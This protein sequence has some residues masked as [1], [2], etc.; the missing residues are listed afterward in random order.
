MSE[1]KK[2]AVV[3]N[4]ATAADEA[5]NVITFSSI[6]EIENDPNAMKAFFAALDAEMEWV[7]Q[8]IQKRQQQRAQ[9]SSDLP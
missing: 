8:Q 1:H 2:K 5:E 7:N 4:Q 9:N 6:E 3:P